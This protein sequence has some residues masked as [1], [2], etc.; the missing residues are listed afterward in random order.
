[1]VTQMRFFLML[2]LI[3]L[4]L[5]APWPG[6]IICQGDENRLL[7]FM[8]S[9]LSPPKNG[10]DIENNHSEVLSMNENSDAKWKYLKQE[11]ETYSTKLADLI[12]KANSEEINTDYASVSMH[13]IAAFQL[14]AQ[15]DRDNV[16]EVRRIFK[17]FNYYNRTDPT[18]ADQLAFN[19]M[20]ACIEVADFAINELQQQLCGKIKLSKP[21]DFS[22]GK[23]ELGSG[24]YTLDGRTVFPSSLTWMPRDDGFLQA[25]GRLGGG[26]YAL[27]N[28]REGGSVDAGALKRNM[29]SA[30]TQKNKNMAPYTYFIG[31]NPAHWMTR[32]HPEVTD[33]ARH[34]TK[35]DID[36]PLI[37]NWLS[38]LFSEM[39]PEWSKVCDDMPQ[40]HL[41]ANE[42]HFAT[43]RYGWLSKNGVSEHTMRKYRTWIAAK[44]KTVEALNEAYGTLY[45][46]VEQVAVKMPIDPALQGGA[47]W[48][49]WC[50]FNMDRVNNWFTFLKNQVQ[51]YDV[52]Q[53]PVTIKTLGHILSSPARD[54]GMDIEYLTKLQDIPGSDLRVEPWDAIFYG[55]NEDKRNSET[56]WT[57]RYA[58][59]WVDQ[60]IML[61][62]TKSLCPDKLFYDS[63]WHGFGAVGWRHFN[64]KREY[65][66]SALWLAFSHGMGAINPWLWGRSI[67]GSL[68]P[69]ADN[70]GELPTQPIALDAYGRTIKELNAHAERVVSMVPKKRD[71]LI[72]YCEEAAIQSKDYMGHIK[73]IYEALKLLNLSVGFTT[74]SEMV[75]LGMTEQTLIMPPTQFISDKSF[76]TIEIFHQGGGRIVLVGAEHSFLKTELGA[77]RL[78]HGIQEIFASIPLSSALCLVADFDEAL[79]PIKPRMEVEISVTDKAGKKAYGVMTNQIRDPA[80]GHMYVLLNNISKDLRIVNLEPCQ[81]SDEKLMDMITQEVAPA[82]LVMEPCDVR[83]LNIQ[84]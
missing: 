24:Y 23:I 25:F 71:L 12:N 65:V 84:R 56:G 22:N 53:S 64:L 3:C 29:K 19:E 40:L 11:L 32:Q 49:D 14:A 81:G 80:T 20:V 70:I 35:Y 1:M 79:S 51:T 82:R 66:R 54:H 33:G 10:L 15:Q 2:S 9:A 58:Y 83:L 59:N 61:D 55:K 44:Y 13:V 50:R 28:L 34:F 45:E 39:L 73:E 52:N 38:K 77:A 30:E 78:V 8:D 43:Q 41:L 69:R 47:I 68:T 4:Y 76:S 63:E 75:N 27:S 16:E 18:E 72:F 74:P 67:D 57:S 62:F 17:S 46:G 26:Y 5:T 21:P 48:Y 37:R 31:H 60:S 7:L 6:S 42:P 36:S